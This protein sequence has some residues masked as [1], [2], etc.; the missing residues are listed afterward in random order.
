MTTSYPS[1]FVHDMNIFG[2]YSN[3][4]KVNA[5]CGQLHFSVPEMLVSKSL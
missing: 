2:Y 5:P 3:Q 1:H 4:I